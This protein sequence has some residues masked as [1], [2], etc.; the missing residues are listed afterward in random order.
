MAT[1]KKLKRLVIDEGMLLGRR[2]CPFRGIQP[3]VSPSL[4]NKRCGDEF[5]SLLPESLEFLAIAV[6]RQQSEGTLNLGSQILGSI[7][8]DRPCMN[9]LK[10]VMIVDRAQ[11]G[12]VACESCCMSGIPF[13]RGHDRAGMDDA[14]LHELRGMEKQ[15]AMLGM[16]LNS[17]I[18][19]VNQAFPDGLP[20]GIDY[21]L[22][23]EG[24]WTY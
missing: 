4:P 16:R 18:L 19:D 11:P 13:C 15:F 14:G 2:K 1:F 23:H 21:E 22:R 10:H 17:E 12:T 5:A 8:V 7:L 3:S 9:R 20:F 6:D 24:G